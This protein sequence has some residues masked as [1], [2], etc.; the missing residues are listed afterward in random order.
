V[1]RPIFDRYHVDLV[2]A[3]HNHRY[4]RTHKLAGDRIVDPKAPGT[5]YTI[6]TSG[7]K[8]HLANPRFDHLM[9]VTREASQMYQV[10]DI[11]S[12]RLRYEAWDVAGTLVDGFELRK[13]GSGRTEYVNH[14]SSPARK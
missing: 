10:I 14:S 6:S 5:T 1:F 3:G 8:T 12:D 13:D 2:L 11:D 4:G 7:P 9:A